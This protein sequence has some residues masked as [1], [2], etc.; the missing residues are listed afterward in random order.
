MSKFAVLSAWSRRMAL[1]AL[2]SL[3]TAWSQ[4]PTGEILGTIL[5]PSGAVVSGATILA[6]GNDAPVPS[7]ARVMQVNITREPYTGEFTQF[8]IRYGI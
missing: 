1:A 8:E 3:A 7:G 4:E 5:D 6:I 2:L